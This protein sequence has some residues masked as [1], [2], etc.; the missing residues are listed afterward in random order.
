MHS[1]VALH[2]LQLFV[3]IQ[4]EIKL[5]FSSYQL[6]TK[7]CIY[8]LEAVLNIRTNENLYEFP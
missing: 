2:T 7:F 6:H 5:G 3:A 1:I 4:G 8:H